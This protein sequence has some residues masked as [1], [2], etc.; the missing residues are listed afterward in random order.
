MLQTLAELAREVSSVLD[1]KD[2][3]E[4]IPN[5][6]SRLTNFTVFS[7]YLLNEQREE[8]SIAYAV[9]YPE[10]IVRHFTLKVGQG[11]VGTAVAEQRPILLNDVDQDP[12]YLAVVPGAKSQLAVPLRNKGQVIGAL[13]LLSDQLGAFT[14]RDEWILRQFAAHVAQAITT[15]RLLGSEREYAETLETLAEIGHEMSA[16]LDPDELLTRLA[17]LIK[18]VIDYRIFGIALLDEVTQMLELKVTIKYGDDPRA[19]LPVR[20]GEGLVGY[21]ALHKEVVLV[22]D[23]TKDPRYIAAVPGVRSELVVPL[24]LKDRCIGVFDLES[25][26]PDAFNKKHVKLLTLLAS[27]AAVAIE[28]A[29]LYE[30]IRTSEARF[31]KELKLAKRVQMAL[32]PQE[33]PKRLKGVDVGWHFD[34]AREL[35]GDFCDFL[36]PEPNSLVVVLGDVS[37]KGVPA[38][39]YGAAIGEMVRGRTFRRRLEKNVTTPAA[40]LAGMNRIL[41]ERNLEEYYCTLCYAMFEFKKQ[42]VTFANSGLPYPVKWSNG[43]AAQIDMPGVPL[44]SFGFSKYEDYPVPLAAGDIFVLCSDGIFEAFDESGTEFGAERV[45]DVIERTHDRPSK[46]IVNEVFAAVQS[47]SGHAPQSDDRTVVVVKINQ[48][49]PD[50]KGGL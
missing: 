26:E 14:E 15:A 36:A 2:L 12:R 7:V 16:I 22:P 47:F 29:R 8:L 46:E 6:I 3:L 42:I 9:G 34:P 20:L 17:H 13:N 39:L 50:R 31:E 24:L 35:G 21:A 19:T 48:L 5:L 18:R 32:L 1:L 33:L 49:G 11:T 30:S 27:E 25:P 43:K 41:H 37:G 28:N 23:V 40:L 4:K 44:G 38:A 10:E 45:I